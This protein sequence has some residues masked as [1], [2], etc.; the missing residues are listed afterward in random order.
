MEGNGEE[1]IE[2]HLQRLTMATVSYIRLE[3]TINLQRFRLY[4]LHSIS[5]VYKVPHSP[6]LG[7]GEFI[8]FFEEEFQ[9][10]KRGR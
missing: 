3:Y 10:V 4:P 2:F 9:V 7:G 5:G 6:P 1:N 8:E